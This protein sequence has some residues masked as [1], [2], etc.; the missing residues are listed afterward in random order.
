MQIAA[1]PAAPSTDAK[2][3]EVIFCA[4]TR[5]VDYQYVGGLNNCKPKLRTGL[6]T[7]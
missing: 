7:N 2:L 4:D 3:K 6:N 1:Q 5:P